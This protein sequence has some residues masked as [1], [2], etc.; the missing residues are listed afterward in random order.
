MK[1]KREFK[2]KLRK[3]V[4]TLR[5]NGYTKKRILNGL[6][7]PIRMQFGPMISNMYR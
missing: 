5:K 3:K 2:I 6:T 1:E 7:D 4:R